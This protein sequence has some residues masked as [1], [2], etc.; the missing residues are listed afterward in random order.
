MGA[1][2]QTDAAPAPNTIDG[3]PVQD[4]L[5]VPGSKQLLTETA[6]VP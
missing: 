6:L 5:Q 4:S 2:L 3:V 1:K